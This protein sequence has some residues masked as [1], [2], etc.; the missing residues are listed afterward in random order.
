MRNRTVQ[1]RL[2]EL[3]AVVALVLVRRNYGRLK[4]LLAA[5]FLA[6]RAPAKYRVAASATAPVAKILVRAARQ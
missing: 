5:L 6:P 3:A 2:G 1:A 4:N